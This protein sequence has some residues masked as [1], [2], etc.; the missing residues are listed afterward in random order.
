VLARLG[1][2]PFPDVPL[3]AVPHLDDELRVMHVFPSRPPPQVGELM[4]T[5]AVE[6]KLP[7][8]SASADLSSYSLTDPYR[9]TRRHMARNVP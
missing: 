4:D 5:M 6:L 2:A 7:A 8:L 1:W 3:I 9:E